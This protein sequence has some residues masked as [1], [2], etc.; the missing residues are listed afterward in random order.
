MKPA[1]APQS[2]QL[3]I[4]GSVVGSGIGCKNVSG[5]SATTC[6]VNEMVLLV[7][8]NPL[9]Q[10]RLTWVQ[11]EEDVE[12]GRCAERLKIVEIGCGGNGQLISSVTRLPSLSV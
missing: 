1:A 11:F 5:W 3:P 10:I 9:L 2:A 12:N 7:F 4:A 6:P 8:V